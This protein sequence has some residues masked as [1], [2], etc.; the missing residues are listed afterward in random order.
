MLDLFKTNGS[1]PPA[2]I[3][4]QNEG[5][6]YILRGRT[7][8]GKDWIEEHCQEGDYNPFG[9]GARLVEHRYIADIVEGAAGD[10]LRVEMQ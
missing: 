7:D 3:T 1:S 9:E 4:V 6:I 2:D 5:S 8:I 10:G